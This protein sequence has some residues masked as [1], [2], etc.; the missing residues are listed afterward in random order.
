MLNGRPHRNDDWDSK[1]FRTVDGM[2]NTHDR[3]L[4]TFAQLQATYGI[5]DE[6]FFRYMQM[7]SQLIWGEN[8][9]VVQRNWVTDIGIS[10]AE[11]AGRRSAERGSGFKHSLRRSPWK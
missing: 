3:K 9:N 5:E 2:R 7:R 6:A 1:G 8:W 11:L 10:F 4:R